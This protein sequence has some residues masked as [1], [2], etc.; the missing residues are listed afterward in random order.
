MFALWCGAEPLVSLRFV[1]ICVHM[2]S[3]LRSVTQSCLTLCDPMDYSPPGSS[4]HWIL[5]A[6]ILGWVVILFCKGSSWPRDRTLVSCI[7]GIFFFLTIWVTYLFF[8]RFFLLIGYCK[9][10]CTLCYAAGPYW[11]SV[12]WRACVYVNPTLLIYP[13]TPFALSNCKFCF[14]VSGFISVLYVRSFASFLIF[15]FNIQV[16]SCDICLSLS[17]FTQ[18]NTLWVPPVAANSIISSLLWL[19]SVQLCICTTSSVLVHLSMDT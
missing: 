18:Y 16:I 12:L 3:W 17:D 9:T 6:R 14:L 1:C 11:L 5:Q 4:P 7:A 19:R 10:V 2:Y 8:F 13:S 15:K